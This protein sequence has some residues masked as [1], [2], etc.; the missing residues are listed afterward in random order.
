MIKVM[1]R[2]TNFKLANVEKDIIRSRT[3]VER[4]NISMRGEYG[5]HPKPVTLPRIRFLER[6]DDKTTE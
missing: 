4:S 5:R 3:L 2:K 6:K 1:K